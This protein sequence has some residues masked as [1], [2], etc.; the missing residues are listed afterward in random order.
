M[1]ALAAQRRRRGAAASVIDIGMIIGAG[2]VFRNEGTEN[3]LR[4]QGFGAISESDF[5]RMFCEAIVAGRPDSGSPSEIITGLQSSAGQ[6]SPPWSDNPRFS[7]HET[8]RENTTLRHADD[9]SMPLKERL[10]TA[11]ND[12]EFDQIVRNAFWTKLQV[13]LQLEPEKIN[14]ERPLVELGIDS[15]MAV[16]IRSWWL[17]QLDFNFPVIKILGGVSA[18][19]R[20]YNRCT[21]IF[22]RLILADSV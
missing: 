4:R 19:Q 15:L 2:Y 3:I 17:K 9:I 20:K 7:H 10:A 11:Q 21:A 1:A 13:V 5:L 6:E 22:T 14:G 18:F 12:A 8:G 16:E